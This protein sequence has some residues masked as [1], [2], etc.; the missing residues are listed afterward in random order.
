MYTV[1]SQTLF[2]SRID[3]TCFA[4]SHVRSHAL[5]SAILVV[6]SSSHGEFV[7][8][9]RERERK[10][11][12][13]RDACNPVSGKPTPGRLH[14]RKVAPRRRSSR[15]RERFSSRLNISIQRCARSRLVAA[16]SNDKLAVSRISASFFFYP[17]D[18]KKRKNSSSFFDYRSFYHISHESFLY[19]AHS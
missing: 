16:L 10:S 5:D 13:G 12:S 4:I 15:I 2:A 17:R 3:E 6:D 8:P 7:A 18:I 1:E 19:N 9:F 11:R 14:G